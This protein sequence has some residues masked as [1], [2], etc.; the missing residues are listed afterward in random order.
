MEYDIDNYIQISVKSPK[1]KPF[2]SI[3]EIDPAMF[4]QNNRKNKITLERAIHC[5]SSVAMYILRHAR[6]GEEKGYSGE[7]VFSGRSV[8]LH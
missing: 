2:I 1:N 5:V 4:L 7:V 8:H 3:K 6:E